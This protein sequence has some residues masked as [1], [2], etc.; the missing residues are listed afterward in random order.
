MEI[1]LE[2]KQMKLTKQTLKQIIKEELNNLL[3]EEDAK[4]KSIQ[5]I[6]SILKQSLP[7]LQLQSS[8]HPEIPQIT[9]VRAGNEDVAEI[10]NDGTVSFHEFVHKDEKLMAI[11]RKALEAKG[12]GVQ[13]S[14]SR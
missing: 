6:Q 1:R 10:S 7:S 9:I 4:D 14:Y 12:I 3:N 8:N 2:T 13:T 11:L 5:I